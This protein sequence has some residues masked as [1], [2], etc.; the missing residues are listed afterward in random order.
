MTQAR[1]SMVSAAVIALTFGIGGQTLTPVQQEEPLSTGDIVIVT[2][3]AAP[4]AGQTEDN[5]DQ[6]A[7]MGK[8]EGTHEGENLGA[9][10]E[11]DT[12][13]IDQPARRNPTTDNSSGDTSAPAVMVPGASSKRAILTRR[14]ATGRAF[15]IWP[16]PPPR[17]AQRRSDFSA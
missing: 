11:N 5:A 9:T 2:N 6:S 4:Q 8:E 15:P 17:P 1:T 7:K 10:P 16:P 3:D 12:A 14:C 13:K